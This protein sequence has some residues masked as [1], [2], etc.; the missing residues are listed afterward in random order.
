MLDDRL[1]AFQRNDSIHLKHKAKRKA[2]V[3]PGLWNFAAAMPSFFSVHCTH[4]AKMP[5]TR[6]EIAEGP[7]LPQEALEALEDHLPSHLAFGN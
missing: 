1:Q 2:Q 6:P 5:C 3:R 4:L 7:H